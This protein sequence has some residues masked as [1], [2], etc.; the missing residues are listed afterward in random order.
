MKIEIDVNIK[1]DESVK[2]FIS[3]LTG[4]LISTPAAAPVVELKAEEATTTRTRR[5]KAEIEAEKAAAA[6]SKEP[7]KDEQAD[8]EFGGSDAPTEEEVKPEDF[9]PIIA[10]LTQVKGEAMAK[11]KKIL[12]D[13]SVKKTA[14]LF[15]RD[16]DP[17]VIRKVY[18]LF[19]ALV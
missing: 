9:A 7:V 3:S 15:E 10:K 12:A 11:A 6:K 18:N 17:R 13:H 8:D 1:L 4:G 5:T 19:K 14:E 16:E 2:T